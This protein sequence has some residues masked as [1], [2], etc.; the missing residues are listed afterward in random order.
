MKVSFV[1]IFHLTIGLI[2]QN[3]LFFNMKY[4][5]NNLYI[6]NICSYVNGGKT[7][8]WLKLNHV[9]LLALPNGRRWTE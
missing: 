4:L 5:K 3:S 9:G 7:V 8:V 2:Y 6:Y 1:N